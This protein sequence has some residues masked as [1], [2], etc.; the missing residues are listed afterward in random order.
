[1]VLLLC[2]GNSFLKASPIVRAQ[3]PSGAGRRD[4]GRSFRSRPTPA[5]IILCNRMYWI[6]TVSANTRPIN[7]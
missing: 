2:T 3:W 4:S 7:D 1:M 6:V 5:M